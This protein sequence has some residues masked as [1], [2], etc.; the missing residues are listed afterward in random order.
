MTVNSST[1]WLQAQAIHIMCTYVYIAEH[2]RYVDV[3]AVT[4]VH[5]DVM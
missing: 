2:G 1:N 3:D 4:D 5:I